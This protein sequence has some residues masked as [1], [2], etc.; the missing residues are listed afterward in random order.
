[1]SG[2]G[3]FQPPVAAA[4]GETVIAGAENLG[5]PA[6]CAEVPSMS[7][8][9]H[10][11]GGQASRRSID[12]SCRPAVAGRKGVDMKISHQHFFVWSHVR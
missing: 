5:C 6:G 2:L 4:R 1:M 12:L 3:A 8:G 10:A 11:I 9:S 7:S